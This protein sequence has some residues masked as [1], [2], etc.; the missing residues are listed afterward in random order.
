MKNRRALIFCSGLFAFA[1]FAALVGTTPAFAQSVQTPGAACT[2]PN[3]GGFWEQSSICPSGTNVWQRPAFQ[4]GP[5]TSTNSTCGANQAGM[6]QWTSTTYTPNNTLE[7]CN[8]T[9]WTPFGSSGVLLGTALSAANPQATGDATTGLVSL[10]G[11]TVGIETG[12]LERLRVTASG[13]V[14]IGTTL[15]STPLQVNGTMAG[16]VVNVTPQAISLTL[17]TGGVTSNAATIGQMAYYSATSTISGTPN[18]YVSGSYI[19][20]GTATPATTLEVNGAALFDS[21]I[22]VTSTAQF[23]GTVTVTATPV[24]TTDAAN[25][26]YV[27]A[28]GGGGTWHSQAYASTATWTKPSTTTTVNLLLVGGGG[29]GTSGANPLFGGGGGGGGGCVTVFNNLPVTGNLTVTIG[30]GGAAGNPGSAGGTTSVAGGAFTVVAA[31]GAGAQGSGWTQYTGGNGGGGALGGPPPT[32]YNQNGGNYGAAGAS[33]A[34]AG[35][36]GGGSGAYL[37]YYGGFG[38]AGGAN[39][40]SSYTGGTGGTPSSYSTG[41][42][43]GGGGGGAGYGGN[44]GNG[45]GGAGGTAGAAGAGCGAGGGGGGGYNGSYGSGAAGYAGCATIWWQQ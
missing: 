8:G 25:K 18:L 21:T 27:D 45:G 2:Q 39:S 14:G 10:T 38:G 28:S 41:G 40:Y 9:A 7:Y 3:Y 13:Y 12:G 5:V 35:G 33:G 34:C 11:S 16:T 31:G 24:N 15:P 43:G 17:G 32:P 29:G 4:F 20:I 42:Q 36:G 22:T 1:L 19:G 26:A 44:G 23:N 6:V 30:S 37:A